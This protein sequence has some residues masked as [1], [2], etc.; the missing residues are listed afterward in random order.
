[1]IYFS[2]FI[3]FLFSSSNQFVIAYPCFAIIYE[4]TTKKNLLPVKVRG[5]Y[6]LLKPDYK[7][8]VF[9]PWS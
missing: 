6:I 1:M 2:D 3:K 7:P 8:N 4:L 9:S 5:F